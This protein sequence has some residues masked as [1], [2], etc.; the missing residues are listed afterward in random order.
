MMEV[1]DSARAVKVV[2]HR[3]LLAGLLACSAA[4]AQE[5]AGAEGP[6]TGAEIGEFAVRADVWFASLS[7]DADFGG[8]GTTTLNV[9]D[10]LGLDDGEASFL[11]EIDWRKDRWLVFVNLF[12]TNAEAD[13]RLSTPIT[14]NGTVVGAGTDVHSEFGATNLAAYVGYDLFENLLSESERTDLRLH[15]FVGGRGLNI[16]HSVLPSGGSLAEYDEWSAALE[17]GVRLSV[18][19]DA[20]EPGGTMWDVGLT[21]TGGFPI[22]GDGD[23]STVGVDFTINWFLNP[24]VGLTFGYHQLDFSVD[25]D[26]AASAY[27]FDGRLAGLML[28]AQI[29]F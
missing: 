22:A 1:R 21:V 25:D 19:T 12:D 11:G 15:A 18:V 14:L 2:I 29:K 4:Q 3:G 28:G 20:G 9:D 13:T 16:D 23:L 8:G 24:N 27:E 10:D 7:G 17:G 6:G 26:S 5:Q